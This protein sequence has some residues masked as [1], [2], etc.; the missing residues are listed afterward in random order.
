MTKEYMNENENGNKCKKTLKVL[1][2]MVMISEKRNNGSQ[3]LRNECE[4]KIL[5]IY[6]RKS[7]NKQKWKKIKKIIKWLNHN[8]W[9][10][11]KYK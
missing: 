6:S 3:W 7:C 11:C 8:W 5:C 4:L 1:M 2:V 10:W 9:Q